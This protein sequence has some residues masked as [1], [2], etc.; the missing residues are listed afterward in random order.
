MEKSQIFPEKKFNCKNSNE[1]V[2]FKKKNLHCDKK[3][4][5]HC[6]ELKYIGDILNRY[7]KI[8]CPYPKKIVF[9]FNIQHFEECSSEYK[10]LKNYKKIELW[11]RVRCINMIK[12]DRPSVEASVPPLLNT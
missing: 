7:G 5:L 6:K 12:F 9:I 1:K 2:I 11:A 8:T 10:G 3:K 4:K